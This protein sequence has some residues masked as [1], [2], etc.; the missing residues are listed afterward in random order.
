MVYSYSSPFELTH[1][2]FAVLIVIDPFAGE[3]AA[4]GHKDNLH[5]QREADVVYIV[6]I[7]GKPFL[8]RRKVSPV[9]LCPAGEP[10][11]NVMAVMLLFV[12]QRQVLHQQRS[13]AH[14]AHLAAED[15]PQLRQ[16]VN[17]Q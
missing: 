7:V 15:V 12:I 6:H 14:E 8:P 11:A 4:D 9:H 1:R 3:D 5:I 10:G 13:W 16:L 2:N 17:A